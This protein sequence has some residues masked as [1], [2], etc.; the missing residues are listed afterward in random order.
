MTLHVFNP[1]HDIAL[2]SNLSNFTAPRAGRQLRHDLSFLPLFWAAEDDVV[3]VDDAEYAKRQ[4]QELFMHLTPMVGATYSSSW[5]EM[6]QGPGA[7][8]VV[9]V[10]GRHLSFGDHRYY[11]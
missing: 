5:S 10:V 1:E 9:Q 11:I 8:V 4:F 6:L 7:R 3:L 2:A